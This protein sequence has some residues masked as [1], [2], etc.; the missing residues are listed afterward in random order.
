[1]PI[2]V[3]VCLM[4]VCVSLCV[5]AFGL[6]MS[7]RSFTLLR[8]ILCGA[9]VGFVARFFCGLAPLWSFAQ[10]P[11]EAVKLVASVCSLEKLLV[12]ALKLLAWVR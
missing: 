4:C 10:L 5:C 2:Y 9:L 6:S 3:C 1:M 12:E 7:V 11:F 8:Y